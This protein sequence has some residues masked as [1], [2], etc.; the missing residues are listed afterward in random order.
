MRGGGPAEKKGMA[1]GSFCFSVVP[2]D[3]LG[4]FWRRTGWGN[5]S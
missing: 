5:F 1:V 4:G 3:A 2:A